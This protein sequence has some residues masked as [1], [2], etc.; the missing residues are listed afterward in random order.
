MSEFK[1]NL[2]G[3][4]IKFDQKCQGIYMIQ[5]KTIEEAQECLT[6][7]MN[8]P[9]IENPYRLYRRG[10]NRCQRCGVKIKVSK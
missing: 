8:Y 5:R 3:M 6:H 10:K 1:H 9:L 4:E 2:F 7:R